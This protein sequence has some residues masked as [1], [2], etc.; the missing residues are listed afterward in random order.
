MGNNMTLAQTC[1]LMNSV[2]S[3]HRDLSDLAYNKYCS[4]CGVCFKSYSGEKECPEC[5]FPC[6]RCGRKKSLGR[7]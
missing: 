2:N 7:D 6:P 3:I 5:R 1:Q 4:R